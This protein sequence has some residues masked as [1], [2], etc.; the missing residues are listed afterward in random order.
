MGTVHSLRLH[1]LVVGGDTAIPHQ[2]DAREQENMVRASVLLIEAFTAWQVG[3]S[4][5]A[6]TV[7]RRRCSLLLF[8]KY[9]RPV[10]LSDATGPM[11]EE[12][13]GTYTSARTKHAYRS[14]LSAFFKWAFR[15]DL[16]AANPMDL[17]DPIRVPRSLPR[18]VPPEA[19]PAIIAS[20]PTRHI[21][22]ALALAAY[23]GLRRAEI[24]RLRADDV[25][26][27]PVPMIEV[28]NGKGGK[29]RSVPMSTDLAALLDGCKGRIVPFTTDHI[30]RACADHIRACGFDMTLHKLR[31][32][33]GTV[34]APL[35]DGD[36]VV[37]GALM[38]HSDPAT[39]MGYVALTDNRAAGAINRAY[40]PE[41]RSAS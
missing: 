11:V 16:I 1:P 24:S 32:T 2:G 10:T 18:P 35:L 12:W 20:A 27:Y 38:G 5:A 23:A 36:L 37:L 33:F 17:T 4:F 22:L 7:K 21:Q 28:R 26:L 41:L 31:H 30:G 8:A 9:I 6:T 25:R 39:T 19:V 14:D 13:L 15:R 34:M 40:R 29:D 3:R